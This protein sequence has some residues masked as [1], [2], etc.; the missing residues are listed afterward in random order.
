MSPRLDL[1]LF[2][3]LTCCSLLLPI[4]NPQLFEQN[5]TEIVRRAFPSTHTTRL[6]EKRSDSP[7]AGSTIGL[8]MVRALD[9]VRALCNLIKLFG[10]IGL[11]DDLV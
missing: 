9:W 8:L 5:G 4:P 7:R 3:V 1:L 6:L 10:K 11:I 2:S